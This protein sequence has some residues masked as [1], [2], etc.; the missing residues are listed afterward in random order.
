MHFAYHVLA[1]SGSCVQKHHCNAWVANSLRGVGLDVF[2]HIADV[3]NNHT[4]IAT[5]LCLVKA[6]L[7][8][9]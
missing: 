8:N 1:L 4:K 9:A 7:Y 6:T 2:E 3:H 5:V